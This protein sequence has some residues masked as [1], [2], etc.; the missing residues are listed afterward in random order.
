MADG[1]DRQ[2]LTVSMRKLFHMTDRAVMNKPETDK[3][4]QI[5]AGDIWTDSHPHQGAPI[6]TRKYLLVRCCGRASCSSCCIYAA[7]RATALPMQQ[8]PFNTRGA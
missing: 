6:C 1:A 3:A 7:L 4:Q 2:L 8:P 5:V